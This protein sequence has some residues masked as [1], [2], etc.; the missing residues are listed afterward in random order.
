[1]FIPI[2]DVTRVVDFAMSMYFVWEM[3]LFTTYLCVKLFLLRKICFEAVC[4]HH[5]T[6][7]QYAGNQRKMQARTVHDATGRRAILV[8]Q[9]LRRTVETKG[10]TLSHGIVRP[11]QQGDCSCAATYEQDDDGGLAL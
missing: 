10:T 7:S 11:D 3:V 8:L 1:M 4:Y 9:F 5:V 6:E 2:S